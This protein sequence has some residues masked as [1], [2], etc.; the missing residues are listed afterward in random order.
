MFD[1][2]PILDINQT[3]EEVKNR[4]NKP[5]ENVCKRISP[6]YYANANTEF[7]QGIKWIFLFG[8][9]STQ[10]TGNLVSMHVEHVDFS[11]TGS[12]THVK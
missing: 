11:N 1:W 7:C 3:F 2:L 8:N 9:N 6:I 5:H 4:L 12:D 10:N